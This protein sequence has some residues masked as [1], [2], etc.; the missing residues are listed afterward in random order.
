MTVLC[1]LHNKS[2]RLDL[3]RAECLPSYPRRDVAVAAVGP[4]GEE[5]VVDPAEEEEEEEV[6]NKKRR[7]AD[8]SRRVGIATRRTRRMAYKCTTAIVLYEEAALAH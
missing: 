6:A 3:T 8:L 4:M 1:S 7:M 2:T 5:T